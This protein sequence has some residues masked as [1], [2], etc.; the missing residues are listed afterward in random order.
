MEI[1]NSIKDPRVVFARELSTSK[2]R[3]ANEACL[4]EGKEQILWAIERKCLV[5]NV[6]FHDKTQDDEFLKKLQ[7]NNI[8]CFFVSDGILKKI[9]DTAYLVKFVG[10]ADIKY[11]MQEPNQDF[12]VV[13][14]NLQDHGNVGAIIRTASAFGISDIVFTNKDSDAFF[15]KT[16][17]ASR[18][19]IFNAHFKKY[20]FGIEAVKDL[21]KKGYQVVATSPHAKNIQSLLKL[22]KLP[23][24]L[25]VGNETD[26]SSDD[27]L[28]AADIIVQIPMYSS[29]ESLNVSIAASI[30]IYELQIKLLMAMMKDKI[31]EG[32]GR[33]LSVTLQ[34]IKQVFDSELKKVGDINS[35][36]LI[37]IMILVF[38]QTMTYTQ[39]THDIGKAGKDLDDLLKP[40]FDNGYIKTEL[41]NQEKSITILQLGQELI[42]KLWPVSQN[43][44]NKVLEGFSDDDK[45]YFEKLLSKI[46][47]N[48]QKILAETQL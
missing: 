44:E 36:Q 43:V 18:G 12:V 16:I 21:Q 41:S 32:I 46:Q 8:Q 23:V 7:A 27:V 33:N 10:I 11:L 3:L 45:K 39:I 24:A 5:Q 38:D 20:S 6:F 19:T 29:V 22:K 30:S 26:G 34:L 47:Y 13:L 17:D 37:L 40:L 25:I 2:G 14:D 28:D 42:A 35:S 1:I 31:Q 48:C 4:L 9:T 15:K